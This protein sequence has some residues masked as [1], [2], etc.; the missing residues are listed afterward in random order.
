[1]EHGRQQLVVCDIG[2][3]HF[4]V[5]PGDSKDVRDRL[6][7]LADGGSGER[8]GG[9]DEGSDV[10]TSMRPTPQTV[11]GGFWLGANRRIGRRRMLSPA[12]TVGRS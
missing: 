7:R 9:Q 12:P 6:D 4:D 3:E 8:I 1:M 5:G 2:R 11:T 10:A